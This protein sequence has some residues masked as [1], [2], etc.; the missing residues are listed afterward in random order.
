[1]TTESSKDDRPRKKKKKKPGSSVP[2]LWIGI[3]GGGLLAILIIAGVVP[4]V[5]PWERAGEKVK[6]VENN[7]PPQPQGNHKVGGEVVREP[8]TLL[9]N[10]RA[11]GDQIERDALMAGFVPLYNAYCDEVKNPNARN[12]DGFLQ[13]IRSESGKMVNAV[14]NKD[15]L[16]N[17]RARVDSD[18]ILAF[19]AERYTSGYYCIRANKQFNYVSAQDLKTA[20]LV[21]P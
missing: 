1:M 16:I 17:F 21:A 14:R 13:S 2:W 18:E 20:G 11:R 7:P 8:K 3:G 15:F 12:L 6:V 9:G 4:A 5:R 10:I 19:E